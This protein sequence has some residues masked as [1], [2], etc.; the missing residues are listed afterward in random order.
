MTTCERSAAD[1][2]WAQ[3][4]ASIHVS[5]V[6]LTPSRQTNI[7]VDLPIASSVYEA[8]NA[9]DIFTSHNELEIESIEVGIYGCKCELDTPLADGDRVEIYRGLRVD[10]RTARRRRH[11]Q[12]R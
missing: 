6:Y 5:V 2:Q 10:P 9:V 4:A 11:A 12:Q 8:L 3:P 7:A 1:Q